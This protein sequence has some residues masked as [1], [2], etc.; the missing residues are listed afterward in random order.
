MPHQKLIIALLI[1]TLL[2]SAVLASAIVRNDGIGLVANSIGRWWPALAFGVA[3]AT[4]G[5]A[6]RGR[7]GAVAA[8]VGTL[9]VLATELGILFYAARFI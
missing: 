1:S 5:L 2:I 4:V 8:V 6:F 3:T 7:V 9:C